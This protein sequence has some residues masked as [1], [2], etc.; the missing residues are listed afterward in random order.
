V[1]L[2][3]YLSH[4]VYPNTSALA[5]AF[6]GGLSM[7]C[8]L[9]IAPLATYMIHLFGTR[10]GLNLGV[11][12][13]TLSLVGA[14][15]ATRKWHI[16][17][18]QGV[19]FGLGLGFL[20]VGG[21]GIIPQWFLRRRSVAAGIMAAGS[22]FGGLIY[23]LAIGAMIP[24]LGLGWAFRVLALLTFSVN[25][26]CANLLR[27]RNKAVGSRYKAFHLPLFKRPEFLLLQG[28]GIFSL[29]GYVVLLFSLPNYALSVGLTARQGSIIAALLNL[30]QGLGRPVV[31]MV[32]DRFG[33]I[34]IAGFL[35]FISGLFCLLIWIFAKTMGVLCFFAVI[36]GTVA[37][38][39]WTT[40]APVCAEVIGLQDLPSGLS[41]TWVL[42]VPPTTVAEVIGLLLRDEN[43]KNNIYLNAQ[44]FTGFMYMGGALCLWLLRGWKVGEIEQKAEEEEAA[45]AN[46]RPMKGKAH[47]VVDIKGSD[48]GPSPASLPTRSEST[49]TDESTRRQ[50]I[51][52]GKAAMWTPITLSRRMMTWKRV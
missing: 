34:N 32:S 21:V 20:F 52:R 17:L 11:F 6:T 15:F 40:V 4:D 41:I 33:R 48:M 26:V 29:L 36:V 2:S 46:A 42:L 31:G 28:W 38:T 44:I 9:L 23:S 3:Y 37:G 43:R 1:F 25:L 24:N 50:S 8:A 30:G 13:Q 49:T 47:E 39:F 27:D 12:F 45:A 14:S 51:R 5:Y 22:G 19:C 10:L 7:S 35:T 18:S 16:F